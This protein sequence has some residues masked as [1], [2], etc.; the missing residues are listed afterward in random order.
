MNLSKKMTGWGKT[1]V[2][3]SLIL[4]VFLELG[5]LLFY[6]IKNQKFF[7]TR[8][9]NESSETQNLNLELGSIRLGESIIERL[10]P[11]FGYV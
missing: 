4:L 5:S 10:H 9:Q 2:I 3:N 1:L 8:R 11:F 6:W 7:Y